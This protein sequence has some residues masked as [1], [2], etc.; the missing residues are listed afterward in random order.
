VS[1]QSPHKIII[2]ASR[3]TDIPAFYMPWFMKQIRKGSFEVTNPFNQRVSRVQAKPDRVHTIVFWSK[4][5]GPYLDK[6]YGD[7]LLKQGYHLFFNFTIN[8][9]CTILEPNL[10]ALSTRL[11]Q[12]EDLCRR[13]GAETINWRFDP[14]C[15]FKTGG[16]PLQD[17][18]QGFSGIVQKA[19][20]CGIV[21]CITSFMDHYPK[22]RRRLS[23]WPGFSFIDPPL[24]KKIEILSGMEKTLAAG[25]IHLSVCC[26]KDLLEKFPE[27][28]SLTGSSCIPGYLLQKIFGGRLSLKKDTGQRVKAGCGCTLSTDI[29]S[30]RQHP[31]YHNC[32]FCYANPTSK[33]KP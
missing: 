17:N 29:G 13:F 6:N 27:S 19:T 21:R 23:R 16:G 22:I 12:L 8:S 3:R 33:P 4:N 9:E 31:C 5:F 30:Y 1:T 24:E 20:E 26:E 2:S 18:L 10:P 25:D 7:Q 28:S 32:L 15:F 14:L 11:D